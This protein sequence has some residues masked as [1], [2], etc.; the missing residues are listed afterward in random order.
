MKGPEYSGIMSLR[1]TTVLMWMLTVGLSIIAIGCG[2]IEGVAVGI[3]KDSGSAQDT[4]A[5]AD[6]DTD[7]DTGTDGDTDTDTDVD[8]DVDTDA[9]TDSGSD[10]DTGVDT[11]SESD[12]I[13]D[14]ETDSMSDSAS[15]TGT[16]TDED[17]LSDEETDTG[18]DT[19][20]ATDLTTDTETAIDYP[21]VKVVPLPFTVINKGTTDETCW[22][23]SGANAMKIQGIWY[24]YKDEKST[25]NVPFR[26]D[27]VICVEGRVI[28]PVNGDY[29]AN[30]G[31]KIG[32][33]LCSVQD[34][35]VINTLSGCTWSPNLN[36]RFA[37]IG[38]EIYGTLPPV[39][40]RVQFW[41]QFSENTA[42]GDSPY[43]PISTQ[44]N[45][46]IR[47]EDAS[48]EYDPIAPPLNIDEVQAVYFYLPT[49]QGTSYDYKFCITN[50][51]ALEYL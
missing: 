12:S 8:T 49:S 28:E 44:G 25:L 46:L 10:T 29:A 50:L 40:A 21:P 38:F 27:N 35:S 2:V 39:E 13:S 16:D 5:D 47:I 18:S 26:A 1:P 20:Q 48:I 14:S 33:D 3:P 4:D 19:D 43:V 15:D 34:Q 30:F 9:D 41:E 42:S 24:S 31:V 37:G 51:R 6:T 11:G 7:T 22:I 32:F 45:H 17:T 36:K 23:P